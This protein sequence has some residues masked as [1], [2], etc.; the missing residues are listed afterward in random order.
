[1]SI[2]PGIE[3]LPDP[4]EYPATC[5]GCGKPVRRLAITPER[6][7]DAGGI[8]VCVKARLEDIGLGKYPDYVFHQPLPHGLIGAPPG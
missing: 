6:W 1:M 2:F 8:T 5:R 4:R 7:E 3:S